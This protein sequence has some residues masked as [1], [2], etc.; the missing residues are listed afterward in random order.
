MK[1]VNSTNNREIE[2]NKNLFLE[3]YSFMKAKLKFNDDISKLFLMSDEQNSLNP[4][5]TTAYYKPDDFS[6]TIF[7]DN[8]HIKDMLRSFAHELIHHNQNLNEPIEETTEEGYAQNNKKLRGLE[9]EAYL[10]GNILFRDW[11]DNKKMKKLNKP[12]VPSYLKEDLNPW[13]NKDAIVDKNVCDALCKQG[14]FSFNI[15][16]L[17]KESKYNEVDYNLCHECL[18]IQR[19]G[20]YSIFTFSGG[21]EREAQVEKGLQREFGN[22]NFISLEC[23]DEFS[24]DSFGKCDSCGAKNIDVTACVAHFKNTG[25][26]DRTGWQT[27]EEEMDNIEEDCGLPG[28]PMTKDDKHQTGKKSAFKKKV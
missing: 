15:D 17:L 23:S 27:L 3:L 11:E 1:I 10:K 19:T 13:K 7:C 4:L 20:D 26:E 5:G 28:S 12:E 14:G 22:P 24:G 25:G 16:A 9:K 21:D 6:V 18:T 2:K 8:R